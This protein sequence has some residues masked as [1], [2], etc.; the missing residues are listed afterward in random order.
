MRFRTTTHSFEVPMDH[1]AGVEIAE[2]LSS[3]GD[4]VTGVGTE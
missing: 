2:A 1:I 4:L 3:V